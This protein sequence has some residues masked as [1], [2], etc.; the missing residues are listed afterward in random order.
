MKLLKLFYLIFLT[1][2]IYNNAQIIREWPLFYFNISR[3]I[4]QGTGVLIIAYNRPDYLLRLIDSL[5]RNPE[6]QSLP[7]IFVLDGGP[8][9]TQNDN[10][11]IIKASKIKH[12]YIIKRSRNYNC[13]P[14]IID[15]I[16]FM[17]EWCHFSR[18]IHIED[19]I[20]VSPNYLTFLLNLHKW[21]KY[22]FHNI[23]AVQAWSLC[24]LNKAQKLQYLGYVQESFDS[25]LGY[26]MD[27]NVWNNIKSLIHEY[28]ELFFNPFRP[29]LLEAQKNWIY[30]KLNQNFA[31][32]YKKVFT[33]GYHP[34]DYKA[35]FSQ[36]IIPTGQDGLLAFC[37][38][39]KGYIK[40]TTLVNRCMNIGRYGAHSNSDAYDTV[41]SGVTFDIFEADKNLKKFV[42][43]R[44]K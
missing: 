35:I 37:L 30:S 29:E 42:I 7:F 28:E 6:A 34:I 33:P 20:V 5:E 3:K 31:N 23:G 40:I 2:N 25:W 19:D 16:S 13:D 44:T 9:S 21:A 1:I 8:D 38:Y 10:S 11:K 27:I 14:N 43:N 12:K 17:F 24:K 39:K 22:N 18:I 32:Y 36:P 41:V 15:A 4:K 26:C